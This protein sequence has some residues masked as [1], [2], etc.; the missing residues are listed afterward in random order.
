[1]SDAQIRFD[2]AELESIPLFKFV[3]LECIEGILAHCTVLE[4][5]RGERFEP[6]GPLDKCFYVLLSGRLALHFDVKEREDPLF[7]EKGDIVGETF[8]ADQSGVPFLLVADEACRIMVMEEDLIWSLAQ[9]SHAAACNMLGILFKRRREPQPETFSGSVWEYA[10][11]DSGIVDPLTG[12]HTRSWLDGVLKRQMSRS[13]TCGKPVSLVMVDVDHFREFNEK[14]GRLSG[15]R[16]LHAVAKAVRNHLRPAELVAR[17]GGDTFAILLPDAD[18]ATARIVAERLRLR[19]TNTVIDMLDGR[20]LPPLS[21]SAGL[22]QAEPGM[23]AHELV[24][25]ALAAL[26]RA[27]AAGGNTVSD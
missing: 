23:G 13:V 6:A 21:L 26:D 1:M 20:V 16:A 27:Q 14:H 17:Y 3:A 9:F 18:S 8:I 12:F 7:L 11:Q 10:F 19:M 24:E 25:I 22:A 5:P 2:A 4:L 15:D